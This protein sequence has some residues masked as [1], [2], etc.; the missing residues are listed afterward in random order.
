MGLRRL[1][2]HQPSPRALGRDS[3]GRR[4]AACAELRLKRPSAATKSTDMKSARDP[5]SEESTTGRD[6]MAGRATASRTLRAHRIPQ[7]KFQTESGA[8]FCAKAQG[9]S[10]VDTTT[11]GVDRRNLVVPIVNCLAQAALGN[12]ANGGPSSK[13]PVA[14]FAK[15]FMTQP[16]GALND[17]NLYGEITGAPVP[18]TTSKSSISS[19]CTVR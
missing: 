8:P 1:L 10:G 6:E 15:F 13:T 4:S 7:G 14:A 9:A 2:G 17:G 19:S 3:S 5:A 12:M 16:Y 18:P 11:G